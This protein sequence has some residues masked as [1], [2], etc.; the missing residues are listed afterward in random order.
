MDFIDKLLELFK[1][2]NSLATPLRFKKTDRLPQIL[3]FGEM[4]NGKSTTGNHLIKSI[5]KSQ[6]K[7]PKL[8]QQFES[9]KSLK[10]VTT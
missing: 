2:I 9:K 8:S 1:Q 7:K 4:G 10:A 5:L 3:L 6:N